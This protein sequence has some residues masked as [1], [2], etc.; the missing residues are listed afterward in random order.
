MLPIAHISKAIGLR[1]SLRQPAL[2]TT[3]CILS[4]HGK[5]FSRLHPNGAPPG[6]E[7]LDPV[8]DRTVFPEASQIAWNWPK[9][10]GV[11]ANLQPMPR[12]SLGLRPLKNPVSSLPLAPSLSDLKSPWP[13]SILDNQPPLPS[14]ATEDSLEVN[15]N[16]AGSRID[17]LLRPQFQHE[18]AAGHSK[19]LS[20]QFL[21]ALQTQ[22]PNRI[23]QLLREFVT[24]QGAE[25]K[26]E[27]LQTAPPTTISA[28]F[29]ALDPVEVGSRLD[30]IHELNIP[31]RMNDYSPVSQAL[32]EF[33]IRRVYRDLF[34]T[35]LAFTHMVLREGLPLTSDGF[36]VLLRC[37]G[38]TSNVQLVKHVWKLMDDFGIQDIRS[39]R[40]YDEFIQARFL[41]RPLYVQ[42]DLARLHL[43]PRDITGHRK[44]G[45]IDPR[46]KGKLEKI[47]L[48]KARARSSRF[49]FDPHNPQQDLHWLLSLPRPLARVW[50]S[51]LKQGAELEEELLCSY[52]IACSRVHNIRQVKVLVSRCFGISLP[53]QEDRRLPEVPRLTRIPSQR[54]LDAIVNSLGNAGLSKWARQL[55][56]ALSRKH[57]TPIPAA[58]WSRLLEY[59]FISASHRLRT[60][61]SMYES[62]FPQKRAATAHDV[63]AVW[64]IMVSEPHNV[65]PTFEDLDKYVKALIQVGRFEDARLGL[66]AGKQHYQLLTEKV[67]ERLFESLHP[68]PPP[69]VLDAFF[70]AKARQHRA[71]YSIQRWCDMWIRM[72]SRH[73]P[74]PGLAAREGIP[75]FV[76]EFRDFVP[77]PVVYYTDA[78]IVRLNLAEESK[79]FSWQRGLVTSAPTSIHKSD[80]S[81]P[82]Q[83]CDGN[84]LLDNAGRPTYEKVNRPFQRSF[85]IGSR[86][87]KVQPW[88]K[89]SIAAYCVRRDT[90][91][92]GADALH[93][94]HTSV[95]ECVEW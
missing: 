39:T 94:R 85:E 66:R 10:D 28:L 6:G 27:W 74:D 3:S 51:A 12:T 35:I 32:D 58:I 29:R 63:I 40:L 59:T 14:T 71:W 86:V 36:V 64:D 87:R 2:G 55:L 30:T 91:K 76:A 26:S 7:R 38:A 42:H 56:V 9:D 62:S 52:M 82:I 68:S 89:N 84:A 37:A 70:R 41:T 79:A 46:L 61:W 47:R 65:E 16:A 23:Y 72:S 53:D 19:T 17:S 78:G 44:H 81:R 49:G 80:R 31:E 11:F 75:D 33:G 73:G 83:D 8:A 21:E 92:H 67:Q 93:L 50:D 13:T 43:R 18:V 90:G 48:Y 95:A 69:S 88:E 57:K 15:E 25:A 1:W 77:H 45:R 20:N 34:S 22:D 5:R 54:L 60:E 24:S 4:S